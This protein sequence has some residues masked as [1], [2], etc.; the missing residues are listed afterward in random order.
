MPKKPNRGAMTKQK[1]SGLF[2]SLKSLFGYYQHK[3]SALLPVQTDY[4]VIKNN[5]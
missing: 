2:T 5:F 3:C 4:K 1:T